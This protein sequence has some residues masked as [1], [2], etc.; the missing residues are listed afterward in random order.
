MLYNDAK[1]VVCFCSS[2][3][4]EIAFLN[5]Q[6]VN[7]FSD[8]HILL[9]KKEQSHKTI[10]LINEKYYTNKKCFDD[11]HFFN[12]TIEE[13]KNN[14]TDKVFEKVI[15]AKRKINHNTWNSFL[16]INSTTQD[17]QLSFTQLSEDVKKV[18]K[19]S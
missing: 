18:L 11:L 3:I 4:S 2:A 8:I 13:I 16:E 17:L 19:Y 7:I 1:F 9:N 12:I 14:N 5:T 6:C 15:N 10:K